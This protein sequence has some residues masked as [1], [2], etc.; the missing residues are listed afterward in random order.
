MNDE[1][2]VKSPYKKI[3][4]PTLWK[5]FKWLNEQ[6]KRVERDIKNFK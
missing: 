5:P 4:G 1:Q 2:E 3:E 6:F